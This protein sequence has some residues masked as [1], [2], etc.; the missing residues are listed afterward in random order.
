MKEAVLADVQGHWSLPNMNMVVVDA[1]DLLNIIG[2]QTLSD[3]VGGAAEAPRG[4]F[5]SRHRDKDVCG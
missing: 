4:C 3:I 5:H 1:E 2:G